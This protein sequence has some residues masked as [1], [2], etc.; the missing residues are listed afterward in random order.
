[1]SSLLSNDGASKV[2]LPSSYVVMSGRYFLPSFSAGKGEMASKVQSRTQES[3]WQRMFSTEDSIQGVIDKM[4]YS[5]T[6][7]S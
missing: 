4:I 5:Q 1:M 7:G 3:P 2:A 6:L